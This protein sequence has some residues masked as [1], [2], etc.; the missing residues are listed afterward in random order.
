MTNEEPGWWTTGGT[1]EED[2]FLGNV[3]KKAPELSH[4][5][6]PALV[7]QSPSN[8][9]GHRHPITAGM[10]I[11]GFW[12]SIRTW[13]QFGSWPEAWKRNREE[14]LWGNHCYAGW[15]RVERSLA[16]S[17]SQTHTHTHLDYDHGDCPVPPDTLQLT[18]PGHQG[19]S[20]KR[21]PRKNL[22][23]RANNTHITRLQPTGI[24]ARMWVTTSQPNGRVWLSH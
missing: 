9:A 18:G 3:R 5:T 15:C 21:A 17:L 8:P 16:L 2:F 13:M 7:T 12:V 6:G 11:W 20:D 10:K 14:E 24:E 19:V 23:S 1:E 4:K 22:E